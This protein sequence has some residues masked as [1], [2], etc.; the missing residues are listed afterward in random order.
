[1]KSTTIGF[2]GNVRSGIKKIINLTKI[3]S[4]DFEIIGLTLIAKILLKTAAEHT[5][6]RACQAWLD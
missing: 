6:H 3:G 4:V 5:T 1:M 2:H